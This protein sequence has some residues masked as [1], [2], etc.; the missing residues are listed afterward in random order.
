[1]GQ[2]LGI[3]SIKGGVGKTTVSASLAYDLANNYH[4]KILLVDANYSAPNLGLHMDIVVPDNTIHDVLAGRSN[5]S[6]AIHE[7]FGV[8]VIPGSYDYGRNV[9]VLKLRDRIQ[10]VKNKYD[11]VIIDSSPSL[12]EEV[13]STILASDH[14]FVVTTPDYPTLSCSI[15]AAK[16]AGQRGKPITGIILNKV[17][18]PNYELELSFIEEALGIPVVA[19][20]PD[21]KMSNRALFLRI[22]VSLYSKRSLFSKEISKLSAAIT[23]QKEPK[24]LFKKMFSF[25]FSREEVNR[26]RLKDYFYTS[27]FAENASAYLIGKKTD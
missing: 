13:L 23:L 27:I 4:K 25:N 15:R 24:S 7:K 6:S 2:V 12:N 9:N 5:L 3:V 14:L 22:P 1:M 18:D 8:D 11:F 21:D 16:L 20:I 26:Q 10:S 19:R 17:R